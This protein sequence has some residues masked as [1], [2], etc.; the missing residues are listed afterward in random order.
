MNIKGSISVKKINGKSYYIHQYRDGDKVKNH[1]LSEEE[2]Y[3]LGF[4]LNYSK[5]FDYDEL[6]NHQFCCEV[7]FSSVL[8]SLIQSYSS[9]NKRY[10][11]ND[12]QNFLFGNGNVGKVLALYGLRRTGKTTLI[13]QSI[14]SMNI[15]DFSKCAYIKISNKNSFSELIDD[16]K[17]LTTHG[18][19]YIFIDEVTI[20]S[21]F[22]SLASTLSDIYGLRSKIILSG[23]DSLGFMISKYYELFDR[24]ILLHTTYISFKEFSEVLGIDSIDTY[25]EYGGLMSVENNIYNEEKI[26]GGESVNEYVDSAIAHNIEH[27]L[28]YYKDGDH[29]SSLYPLYEKGELTNV[30]NRLVEDTNH[31]FAVSVIEDAF[32][33]HD[34]GSLKNLIKKNREESIS[35]S[36]DNINEDEII[37]LLMDELNIINKNKQSIKIDDSVIKEIDSYLDLLDLCKS[38]DV[39]NASSFKVEKRKVFI[40]P[41]LR[42]SQAKVLLRILMNQDKVRRLPQSIKK[43]IEEKLISDIKGRLLEEIVLYQTS[44]YNKDTFKMLFS[45][46]EIDMITFSNQEESSSVYEIKYSKEINETQYRFL[47]KEDYIDLINRAYYPVKDKFVIYRGEDKTIDG[48]K[49]INVEKYLKSL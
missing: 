13:F 25:I 42:F 31:R 36:L 9:F 14:L 5:A 18:F 10:L 8:Y 43:I 15:S 40:Q 17:Y 48:I 32:K 19:K 41:G 23:T 34:Y 35:T 21:D 39:V 24:V 27:S 30:I 33:S 4:I 28:K 46:G 44:L 16:L 20:L 45:I 47:K 3:S 2:A 37:N 26:F 29:F 38:V 49:Y 7:Q 22:Q 11:F 12:M 1:S 6:I